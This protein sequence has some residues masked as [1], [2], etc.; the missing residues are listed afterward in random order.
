M[1]DNNF[2]GMADGWDLANFQNRIV[3]VQI[4]L[5]IGAFDTWSDFWGK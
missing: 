1:A 4:Y 3:T 5:H 2:I